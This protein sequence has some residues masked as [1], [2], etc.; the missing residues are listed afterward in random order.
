MYFFLLL[1]YVPKP[2]SSTPCGAPSTGDHDVTCWLLSQ[3]LTVVCIRYTGQFQAGSHRNEWRR[4]P[5]WCVS[6]PFKSIRRGQLLQQGGVLFFIFFGAWHQILQWNIF[7][8]ILKPE[9]PQWTQLEMWT[10]R[11][12]QHKRIKKGKAF[13]FF[14]L[15]WIFL[16]WVFIR[17]T[18]FF[19]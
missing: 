5:S 17:R 4:T 6:F 1:L 3:A 18:F 19:F 15:W 10:C 2:L 12:L 13:F 11:H 7:N 9:R 14:F 16:R 8:E